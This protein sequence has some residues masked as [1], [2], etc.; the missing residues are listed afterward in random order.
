MEIT[1]KDYSDWLKEINN[2]LQNLNH[3]LNIYLKE[4]YI[5]DELLRIIEYE[6]DKGIDKIKKLK[7]SLIE[8]SKIIQKNRPDNLVN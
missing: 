3:D 1:I 6:L 5:I 2:I 7:S 8:N 4:L